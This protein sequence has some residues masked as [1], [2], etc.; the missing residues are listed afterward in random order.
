MG[1]W[2][3]GKQA[4]CDHLDSGTGHDSCHLHRQPHLPPTMPHCTFTHTL[5]A[6]TPCLTHRATL[7][8][9]T[10]C[11]LH[12]GMPL[13]TRARCLP[14]RDV[15]SCSPSLSTR[16]PLSR[17]VDVA[18]PSLRHRATN[19]TYADNRAGVARRLALSRHSPPTSRLYAGAARGAGEEYRSRGAHLPCREDM[20]S[21]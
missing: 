3:V 14:L 12:G 21:L 11:L 7:Y 20:G 15:H 18:S 1:I 2:D 9:H 10:V 17:C 8:A 16:W 19:V 6:L 5:T 13:R 4:Q